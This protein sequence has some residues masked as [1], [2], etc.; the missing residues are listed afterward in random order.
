MA[1]RTRGTYNLPPE[2]IE[3]LNELSEEFDIPPGKLLAFFGLKGLLQLK[4]GELSFTDLIK[5]HPRSLKYGNTLD[6]DDLLDDLRGN[7]K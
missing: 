1:K 4:K 6:L 7:K 3:T 5:K 2:L